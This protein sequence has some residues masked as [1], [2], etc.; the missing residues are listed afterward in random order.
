M[1]LTRED[2]EALEMILTKHME[3]AVE[4]VLS[5]HME[6]AV[7][8]VLSKY[9]E[10]AV[11]SVLSKYRE[12][13]IETALSKAW[14]NRLTV[15][16]EQLHHLEARLDQELLPLLK[17]CEVHHLERKQEYRDFSEKLR[18]AATDLAILK[19]ASAEQRRK[20]PHIM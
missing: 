15:L 2:K 20:V 19:R 5:K 16:E 18:H 12:D 3:D 10:D 4:S 11:E 8:S 6:D 7:E 9:M 14:E 13:A 17:R 1:A